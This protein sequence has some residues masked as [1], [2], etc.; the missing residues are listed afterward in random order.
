MAAADLEAARAAYE[1]EDYPKA[2]AE[3]QSLAAEGNVGAQYN[4]AVFY[5]MLLNRGEYRRIQF[6]KP[7]TIAAATELSSETLDA[8]L[9]RTA[10]WGYGF[11][12]G[13]RQPSPGEVGPAMGW[14]STVRTFGHFGNAS[15]MA[16]A[17][18][19]RELVVTFTCDGLL[20]QELGRERWVDLSNGVWDCIRE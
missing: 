19:E 6:L 12:L 1:A 14:A 3:Y 7:E 8:F 10:R 16:W 5:Q 4:L 17:D 13:G 9:G 20:S 18:P 2:L 15:S 11:H